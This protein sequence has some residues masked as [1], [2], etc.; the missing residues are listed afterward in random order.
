MS[1]DHTARST[2]QLITPR[3]A[4]NATEGARSRIK[5]SQLFNLITFNKINLSV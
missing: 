2:C 1:A 4:E 3:E 5:R